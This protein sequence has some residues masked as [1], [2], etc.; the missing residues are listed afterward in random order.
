MGSGSSA[1]LHSTVEWLTCG[2]RAHM[3]AIVQY[4]VVLHTIL[5]L[6]HDVFHAPAPAIPW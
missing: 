5:V 3:S 2:T 6:K 1:V 4:C